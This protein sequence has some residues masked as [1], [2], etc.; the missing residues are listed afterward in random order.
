MT[1]SEVIILNELTWKWFNE[2]MIQWKYDSMCIEMYNKASVS[3]GELGQSLL[4][5]KLSTG[6]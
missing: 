2:N 5:G 6:K 4:Y 3:Q 1:V